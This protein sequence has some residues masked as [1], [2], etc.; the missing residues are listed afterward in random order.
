MD[1]VALG[2]AELLQSLLECHETRLRVRIV[3]GHIHEHAHA[4][5]PLAL[6]CSRRKRP[7]RRCT[8]EKGDEPSPS[9][10]EHQTAPA[11]VS[12]LVSLPHPQPAAES[13]ASPWDQPE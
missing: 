13:P 11:L 10:V 6:L 8:A 12:P 1:I 7:C 5:H 2:P 9:R 3:F 4:A